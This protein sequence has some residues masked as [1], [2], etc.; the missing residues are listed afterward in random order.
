MARSGE[1]TDHYGLLVWTWSGALR[2]AREGRAKL[3]GLKS[4]P[5]AE[6][7]CLSDAHC[8]LKSAVQGYNPGSGPLRRRPL[9]YSFFTL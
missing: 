4:K 2:L 3:T 1:D 6:S 9:R 8:D 7:A 5:L